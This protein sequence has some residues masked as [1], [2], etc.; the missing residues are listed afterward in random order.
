MNWGGKQR[1]MHFVLL[2][3]CLTEAG[4]DL[5]SIL[6]GLLRDPLMETS[7]NVTDIGEEKNK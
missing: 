5:A 2:S 6:L 4:G 1:Q 7:H 3:L